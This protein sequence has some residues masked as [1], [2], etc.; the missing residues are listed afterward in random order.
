MPSHIRLVEP[1]RPEWPSWSPIAAGVCSCTK[2]T[3]R[4]N[5]ASASSSYSPQHAGVIRPSG[6]TQVISVI[7]RPAPPRALP[8][9]G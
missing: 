5:A 2:S 7:T 1:L 8:V 3:I 4:R 6:D 9:G